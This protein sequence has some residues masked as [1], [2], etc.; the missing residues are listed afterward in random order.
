M[1]IT[2]SIHEFKDNP[3]FQEVITTG[4]IYYDEHTYLLPAYF[5]FQVKSSME[6]SGVDDNLSSQSKPINKIIIRENV[7]NPLTSI[8]FYSNNHKTVTINTNNPQNYMVILKY[9]GIP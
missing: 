3:L 9:E 8:M 2:L 1:L 4:S 7:K 5:H 6:D